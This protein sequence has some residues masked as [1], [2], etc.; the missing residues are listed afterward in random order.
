MPTP[1]LDPAVL[2]PPTLRRVQAV[3]ARALDEA[4]LSPPTLRRIQAPPVARWRPTLVPDADLVPEEVHEEPEPEDAEPLATA[5]PGAQLGPFQLVRKL[6]S[7]ATAQVW[8]AIDRRYDAPVALKLFS[9]VREGTE[10]DRV[11]A[12]ASAMSRIT[13]DHVVF[14][15]EAGRIG[16]TGAW[17]LAMALYRET[18]EGEAEPRIA[19]DLSQVDPRSVEE[20]V[21]WGVQ[22]ARALAAAHAAGVHHQDLKP[23]NVLCLPA[24]RTVR[25]GDFGLAT[26]TRQRSGGGRDTQSWSMPGHYC[27]GTPVFMAPEQARGLDH[28]PDPVEDRDWLV[29]VDV[30]GLGAVLWTLFAEDPPHPTPNGVDHDEL[31]RVTTEPVPRLD[32]IKTRLRVP[33]R[34]ARVIEK[35]MAPRAADRYDSAEALADELQRF[36]DH[37]PLSI[38]ARFAPVRARLWVQRHPLQAQTV[39]MAALALVGVWAVHSLTE[40]VTTRQE[41][42]R[43]AEARLG[44]LDASLATAGATLD[45]AKA[46]LRTAQGELASAHEAL[47]EKSSALDALRGE[48]SETRATLSTAVEQERTRGD[49]AEAW[50]A[51]ASDMLHAAVNDAQVQ[52]RKASAEALR[53][54]T[55]EA[56]REQAIAAKQQ[57]EAQRDEATARAAAA[58]AERDAALKRVQA[59]EAKVAALQAELE[60]AEEEAQAVRIAPK[61]TP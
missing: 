16:A 27:A 15:R 53:A 5:S 3:P 42:L 28:V 41:E 38:D 24:S 25:L 51:S 19:R 52:L 47:G 11:V 45:A 60:A 8:E 55:A 44:E 12:E 46:Q 43:A 35:A 36:L 58:Q 57:A 40:Q 59:A 4:L 7:G 9:G 10:V 50:S 22:I 30:Y 31:L 56:G 29:G 21:R 17:Y 18:V 2:A 37:R 13:H 49:A 39:A 6:G 32:A 14:I 61:P 20:I 54:D 33:S 26:L 23:E 34:L 1:S 48:Y